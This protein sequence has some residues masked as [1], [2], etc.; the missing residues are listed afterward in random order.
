[1][2]KTL[3]AAGGALLTAAALFGTA[4]TAAADIWTDWNHHYPDHCGV[5]VNEDT[6]YHHVTEHGVF[7]GTREADGCKA[8]DHWRW[9]GHHGHDHH[10]EHRNWPN[11]GNGNWIGHGY[12]PGAGNLVGR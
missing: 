12:G 3:I 9:G 2:R 7:A 11:S 4:G 1:M 10:W 8:G 5:G 6:T